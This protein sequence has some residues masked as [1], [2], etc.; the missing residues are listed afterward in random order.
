MDIN[1]IAE[2][3]GKH[4]GVYTTDNHYIRGTITSVTDKWVE[5]HVHS[6]GANISLHHTNI[7]DIGN[8][9]RCPSGMSWFT[10]NE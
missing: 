7:L 2:F 3:K 10:G 4:T 8:H 9:I 5:I 6:N 1:K